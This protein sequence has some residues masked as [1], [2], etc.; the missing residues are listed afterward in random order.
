MQWKPAR[1]TAL[2]LI[3]LTTVVAAGCGGSSKPSSTTTTTA[4]PATTAA[5]TTAAAATTS[6]AP[7]TTPASTSPSSLGGLLSSGN[8]ASLAG[9]EA[10]V[11]AALAGTAPTDLSARAAVLEQFAAK[12][13]TAIRPDFEI[14]ASYYAKAIGALKGVSLSGGSTPSP[15]VI[16]KLAALGASFKSAQFTNALKAV[17]AWVESNCKG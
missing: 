16:A 6:A 15:S 7:A 9:L 2:S 4:T 10:S 12:T 14:I 11:G 5:A 13:P 8:C 1:V 3:A 17:E